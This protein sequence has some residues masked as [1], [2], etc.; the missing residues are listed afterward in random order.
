MDE[1]EGK[2]GKREVPEALEGS[3]QSQVLPLPAPNPLS[4]YATCPVDLW[5][6]TV[7]LAYPLC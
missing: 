4:L 2:S 1:G 6:Y 3:Q 7:G 5:F